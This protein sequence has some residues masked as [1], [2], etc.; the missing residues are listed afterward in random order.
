LV[1]Q[2]IP[3][4][5]IAMN[6]FPKTPSSDFA[7]EAWTAWQERLAKSN[8]TPEQKEQATAVLIKLMTKRSQAQP[9]DQ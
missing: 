7:Q 5:R 4:Y 9:N 3:R 8:L 6:P 2:A 1:N